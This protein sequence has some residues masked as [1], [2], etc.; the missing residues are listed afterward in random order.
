MN[1]IAEKQTLLH[2]LLLVNGSRTVID[3]QPEHRKSLHTNFLGAT[4]R[5][6]IYTAAVQEN[7]ATALEFLAYMSQQLCKDVAPS[8]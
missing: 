4:G 1:W 7:C 2:T 3:Q 6:T 8:R 5:H